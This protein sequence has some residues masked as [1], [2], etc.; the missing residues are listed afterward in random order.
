MSSMDGID[1]LTRFMNIMLSHG[2][3]EDDVMEISIKIKGDNPGGL[4]IPS[5]TLDSSIRE[6]RKKREEEIKKHL[7][8]EDL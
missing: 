6:Y 7:K 3:K 1:K 4:F 2:L 8:G 5:V